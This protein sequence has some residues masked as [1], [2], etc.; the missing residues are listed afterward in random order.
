[1]EISN[2]FKAFKKQAKKEGKTKNVG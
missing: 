1:V 2:E